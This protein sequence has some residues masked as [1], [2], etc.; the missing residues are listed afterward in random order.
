MRDPNSPGTTMNVWQS[1]PL[2]N[3]C[4]HRNIQKHQAMITIA[5]SRGCN[6]ALQVSTQG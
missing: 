3:P 6:G 4:S 5:A 1:T 2:Q